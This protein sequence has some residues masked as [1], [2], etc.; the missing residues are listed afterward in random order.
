MYYPDREDIYI[1]SLV[2][3]LSL[4][5]AFCLPDLHPLEDGN[6]GYLDAAYLQQMYISSGLQA[7][8]H[9]LTYLSPMNLREMVYTTD[10][11]TIRSLPRSWTQ[12]GWFDLLSRGIWR[13]Q[14]IMGIPYLNVFSNFRY[15]DACMQCLPGHDIVHE[16]YSL[17][18]QGV[19]MA[20]RKLNLPYILF[21]DADQLMEL[22]YLG[23]PITGL[24]RR[25]AISILRY[26][27]RVARGVICVSDQSKANLINNW[28]V[29]E[30]KIAVFP[31]AVDVERFKP[32]PIARAKIR[33]ILGLV[34]QPVIIFVGNFYQWHDVETL[35][36]AFARIVKDIPAARL[37]LVGDGATRHAMMEYADRLNLSQFVKFTGLIAHE[38]VPGYLAAADIGIVPYPPMDTDLWLS[39]LKLYEY[40]ACGL[41]II[42]SDVGQINEVINDGVNGLLVPPGDVEGMAETIKRLFTDMQLRTRLGAQ[43]RQDAVEK[44]SWDRY[45][46]RLENIFFTVI[47]GEPLT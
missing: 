9:Q 39:P 19:A 10:L 30:K 41:A 11:K 14:S 47:A 20:C 25:R 46:R 23:E 17:Y 28:K 6:L 1:S 43:A 36:G 44:H 5:I 7:R 4:R 24:L 18:N 32:D 15:F 31:N 21:F 38:Q 34:D 3:S 35:L 29:P 2:G 16:R 26:N 8:G 13:L 27:L 33:E 40:M 42:A 37:I 22:D 12:T 45:I